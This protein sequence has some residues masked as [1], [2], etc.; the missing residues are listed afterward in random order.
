M[1]EVV[2]YTKESCAFC[3]R[4]KSLFD[5]R[6]VSYREIDLEED[7]AREEEMIRLSSGRTEV[8]QIFINGIHIGGSDELGALQ[9]SGRLDELLN[10]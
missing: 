6:G 8:P 3:F 2:I 10:E 4:V 9:T 5:A 1:A 7:P